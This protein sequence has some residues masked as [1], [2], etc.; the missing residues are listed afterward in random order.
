MFYAAINIGAHLS[1]MSDGLCGERSSWITLD[2]RTMRRRALMYTSSMLQSE[3]NLAGCG[4]NEVGGSL[5]R[6]EREYIANESVRFFLSKKMSSIPRFD[7]KAEMS[8]EWKAKLPFAE[9]GKFTCNVSYIYMFLIRI[10]TYIFIVYNLY[11]ARLH[12]FFLHSDTFLESTV[13]S[14][15]LTFSYLFVLMTSS[16]WQNSINSLYAVTL[17]VIHLKLKWQRGKQTNTNPALSSRNR[18][19][20]SSIPLLT[21]TSK[22]SSA[23]EPLLFMEKFELKLT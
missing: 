12:L 3:G 18:I 16:L 5:C 11:R 15:Q 21:A 14:L 20:P 10:C 13:T 8:S 7:C 4:F 23:I 22:Y 6:S 19:P 1:S 9:R 2:I 17:F